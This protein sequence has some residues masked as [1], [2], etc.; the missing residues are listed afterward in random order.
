MDIIEPVKFLYATNL[1]LDKPLALGE[2]ADALAT[3]AR[4][5]AYEATQ[6]LVDCALSRDVDFVLL[7][8]ELCDVHCG[9]KA[10][11]FLTEQ[12]MR[13]SKAGIACY[14]LNEGSALDA[15]WLAEFPNG[16]KW[17][18]GDEGN[19]GIVTCANRKLPLAPILEIIPPQLQGL[20]MDENGPKGAWL[21][22]LSGDGEP[23]KEFIELS[24]L[25][26]EHCEMDVTSIDTEE[27]LAV[28][29]RNM[30]NDLR[31]R[32]PAGRPILLHLKLT[33]VVKEPSIFYG[34][35]FVRNPEVLIKKLNAGENTQGNFVLVNSI[36][37]ETSPPSSSMSA[38]EI[39]TLEADFWEEAALFKSGIDLR[40]GLFDILK[41]RGILNHIIATDAASLLKSMTEAD[42][43]LI[44]R[45]GCDMMNYEFFK[46]TAACK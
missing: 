17:L 37:D 7:R 27:D 26:W 43:E 9:P 29:W 45:E 11:L 38:A 35:D 39:G 40:T 32:E 34:E 3:R 20:G 23:K 41:E 2:A 33:G 4:A 22:S 28:S 18:H 16:V 10:L 12:T 31:E 44:L 30:K 24:V 46:T 6:R 5:V 15:E 8:G 14:I 1:R 25:C 19:A 21:V 13:L 36:S 42:V